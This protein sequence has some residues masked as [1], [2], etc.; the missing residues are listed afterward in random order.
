MTISQRR[1]YYFPLFMRKFVKRTSFLRTMNQYFNTY[2]ENI[3]SD[4]WHNLCVEKGVLRQYDKSYSW[5]GGAFI[6]SGYEINFNSHW[7]LT[8]QLEIAYHNN[9]ATLSSKEL[10]F[11]ANHANWQSIW[12]VNIPVVA[13]F[14]FPISD[15]LG[16]RIGAGPY[17]Q[18]AIAG[19]QY[20]NDSDQKEAMSGSFSDR[21][22][23]GVLGEVAVETGDHFSYM[24]RTQYP[25]LNE[26]WVRK[27]VSLSVGVR[28]SF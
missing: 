22:N 9:G 27:T 5:G 16:L 2:Y 1:R 18:E 20:R 13:S 24:F 21:F 4:F 17:L 25:F 11:Y 19:R 14:R 12:S 3:D 8:P 23:V 7:I 6:G 10:S 15:N 28:Y 26:G